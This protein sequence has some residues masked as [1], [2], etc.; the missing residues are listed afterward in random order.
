MSCDSSR[1]ESLIGKECVDNIRNKCVVV[2]G[3][4]GVGGYVV[5][6]LARSFV[7]TLILV[8]YDRVDITNLNRQIIA[9][10]SNIGK[11]K[12]ECFRERIKDIN[13]LCNVI[14]IDKFI[15]ESNYLELFKYDIDFFVD[16]CDSIKT[17]KYVIKYCLY[18]N[19]PIISCM[20]SGN[21]MDPSKLYICDIKNTFNDPVARII[22][23]FI[24]DECNGMKL[25]V[26]SSTEVPKKVEGVI[27]SNSFV[28]SSAGLLIGAHV[29]GE[30]TIEK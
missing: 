5:E 14:L 19:I 30:F 10:H 24:K 29:V 23:K 18:N 20:G 7:G 11:L 1:L 9:L 2:L 21:K 16:A 15:D 4:G 12:T 22:R 28:P 26:L 3:L 6:S 25:N 13:P 27:A 17:K 8:D